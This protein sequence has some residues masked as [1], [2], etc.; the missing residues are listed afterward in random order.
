[1]KFHECISMVRMKGEADNF[2]PEVY[3]LMIFRMMEIHSGDDFT[4]LKLQ[5]DQFY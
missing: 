1:M 4:D 2:L 3:W 5:I